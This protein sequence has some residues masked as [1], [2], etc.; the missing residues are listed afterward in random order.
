MRV[1]FYNITLL[2]GW[3]IL[4][5]ENSSITS[6]IKI[7][8]PIGALQLSSF[9]TPENYEL[10]VFDELFDFTSNYINNTSRYK[11][12][13]KVLE[14]KNGLI[15][16]AIVEDNRKWIFAICN[17]GRKVI[18]ATYNSTLKDFEIEE[19]EA[20]KIIDSITF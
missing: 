4:E 11:E 18:F 1:D 6:I 7:D 3:K 5:Y 9:V 2:P 8:S 13:D 16:N 19:R 17:S 14:I 10:N 20:L 12:Y 15:L